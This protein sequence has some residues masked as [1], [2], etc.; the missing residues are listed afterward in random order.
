MARLLSQTGFSSASPRSGMAEQGEHAVADHVG[1]GLVP[2]EEQQ[3]T[4]R[5]E[6]VLGEEPGVLLGLDHGGQ[7]V[8]G[9]FRAPGRDEVAEVR[10]EADYP[11]VGGRAGTG[12]VKSRIRSNWPTPASP[13]KV[14]STTCCMYG[15]RAATLRA[16]NARAWSSRL[17]ARVEVGGIVAAHPR[18]GRVGV[19]E[20]GLGRYVVSDGHGCPL[21]RL[22]RRT[23]A[24]NLDC[25]AMATQGQDAR[26][27][28]GGSSRSGSVRQRSAERAV[29]M[30]AWAPCRT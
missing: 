8:V 3:G 19:R 12:M 20:I 6:F 29:G 30:P 25:P 21:S 2:G 28:T 13:S 9:R 23:V 16:E 24:D 4:A 1:S 7:H 22:A 10:V 11:V 17:V 27:A 18:V 5:H 15:S 26:A 14:A